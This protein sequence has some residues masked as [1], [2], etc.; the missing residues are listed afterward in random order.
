MG[1]NCCRK[2]LQE[3]KPVRYPIIELNRK[4][5][6]NDDPFKF[7][8]FQARK[9]IKLLLSEDYLYK[10]SLNPI[11]LF[12]D[13]Q[14]EN[15]FMG[16]DEYTNFPYHNI[17]NR[18]EF[19]NLLMKFEDHRDILF[20]WY[21]DESK[22][23]NIIKLW[24]TNLC[25]YKMKDYSDER[26]EREFNNAGITDIDNFIV[27]FRTIISGSIESKASNISNYLKDEYEDFYTLITACDDMKEDKELSKPKNGGIFTENFKNITKKLVKA[28]LPLV[29]NYAKKKFLNL[30]TLSKIQLKSGILN[31]FKDLLLKN[32]VE[33]KAS[34][35][36]GFENVLS[37]ANGLKNGKALSEIVKLTKVYFNNPSVNLTLVATSFMNLAVS[38]KTYYDNSVEFDSK[39]KHFSDRME[40]INSDFEYHKKQI[41]LLDLNDPEKCLKQV[42]TI[43]KQIYQDKK[44]AIQ[45]I[46]NIDEEEK[47]LKQDKKNAGIKKTLGCGVGVALGIVGGIATGGVLPLIGAVA[48][49]VA[50][51]VNIANLVKI[52]KQLNIY[53][54][55]KE[56]ENEKY[57]EIENSLAELQTTYSKLNQRYIPKNLLE[58][59]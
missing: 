6:D 13:E 37:I 32:I 54:D 30:N 57:E 23:D 38:V 5:D 19:K 34:N 25:L 46:Q 17:Q 59:D 29:K 9:L 52:K 7:D 36:I 1:C 51:G 8:P 45:F 50:M 16:N 39:T 33:N 27:D 10:N 3:I 42:E 12:N 11:L 24:R 40:S 41:G 53:K 14:L 44:K 49:G 28:T 55:Y 43:G 35:P 22:Y 2:E 56:R 58:D 26:L 48:S 21:K 4:K 20:E 47:H 18:I 31:K 15:L